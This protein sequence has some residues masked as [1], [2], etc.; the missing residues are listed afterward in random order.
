[1]ASDREN[2][3]E[4]SVGV[5]GDD[6]TLRGKV[7]HRFTGWIS[8][9]VAGSF[10]P[11]VRRD[12]S[13]L[14]YTG[15]LKLS[16]ADLVGEGWLEPILAIG[17]GSHSQIGHGSRETDPLLSLS[18]A[19]GLRLDEKVRAVLEGGN[20]TTFRENDAANRGLFFAG[21]AFVF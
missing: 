6:F 7:G 12:Y 18:A 14:I 13:S 15:A 1:M 5:I 20:L 4:P 19:V 10:T 9:E 8:L 21:L 16:L 17:A 11:E 2:Y 3:L